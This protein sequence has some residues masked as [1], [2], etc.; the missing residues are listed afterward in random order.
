MGN[1]WF[2]RVKYNPANTGAGSPQAFSPPWAYDP[3]AA[4]DA[5]R[6]TGEGRTGD[7]APG[8]GTGRSS[9]QNPESSRGFG[10]NQTSNSTRQH[11]WTAIANGIA[12]SIAPAVMTFLVFHSIPK[13][14][15]ITVP[16]AYDRKSPVFSVKLERTSTEGALRRL[17]AGVAPAAAAVVPLWNNGGGRHFVFGDRKN[18]KRWLYAPTARRGWET[19]FSELEHAGLVDLKLYEIQV[20]GSLTKEELDYHLY[21]WAPHCG[22]EKGWI[23]Y[24]SSWSP[25]LGQPLGE[26][27]SRLGFRS[28]GSSPR[29]VNDC[30]PRGT[31][32]VI[33]YD[34]DADAIRDFSSVQDN[35]IE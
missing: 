28:P 31:C 30:R 8:A 29:L 2:P 24:W 11:F 33:S 32:F 9:P 14:M 7:L 3:S 23:D 22:V 4:T 27:I 17:V 35:M 12:A 16:G 13:P 26:W 19:L 34:C 1:Q 25:K 6:A 15:T 20:R 5:V 18:E 21:K 10:R